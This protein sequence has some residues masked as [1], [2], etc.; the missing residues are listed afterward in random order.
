MSPF[1]L[2]DKE[3][4]GAFLAAEYRVLDQLRKKLLSPDEQETTD[5]DMQTL[6][7]AV[8]KLGVSVE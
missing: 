8:E 4:I 3:E 5:R 7:Q 1:G 6:K 2:P